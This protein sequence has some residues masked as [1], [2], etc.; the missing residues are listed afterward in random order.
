MP[1]TIIDATFKNGVF[2]P[3]QR[4]SLADHE[5]V[6]LIIEPISTPIQRLEIVGHRRDGRIRLSAA[7]AQEIA[8]SPEFQS[9]GI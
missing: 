2:V 8:V 1:T 3:V 6:R 5:R 9:N 4:P 7:L